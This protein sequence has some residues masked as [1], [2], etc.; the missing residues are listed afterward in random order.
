MEIKNINVKEWIGRYSQN[1][2][3]KKLL[4]VLSMD[5]LVRASGIILLPIYLRLMTQEEYGLYNYILSIIVT[6]S[7]I[8]NFGLYVSQTKFY[9]DNHLDEKRK[10]VLFNIAFL[11]SVAL[12]IVI[13]PVYVFRLDFDFVKILFKNDINYPRFRWAMLL[14]TIVSVYTV[15]LS[16]YF[17]TS[18]KIK[19]FRRYNLWRLIIVNVVALACLYYFRNDAIHIR[20]IC[21]YLSE[22]IVLAVFFSFYLR[23][24]FPRID[25]KII[26]NSLKLGLPIMF[27]AIWGL[28]SNYSDKFFLEKNGTA[29]DLSYYY[30]AFSIANVLYMICTAVQNSW[31]PSFLKEKDLK[32]NIRKTRKLISQLAIVLF[33]LSVMLLVGLYVAIKIKI[34]SDKYIP[35]MHVLPFLLVAQIINGIVLIYSN[36]M[37]YFERTHW[38]LFIGI[39]TSVIGLAG[40]YFLVPIWGVFGAVTSYLIVQVT[41]FY[42]Y[43]LVIRYKIRKME[44]V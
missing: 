21:T 39:F 41:Y 26:S 40:S 31:L 7:V 13:I 18:E 5:I 32:L 30:L 2:T 15:I 42:L 27:S 16:N 35:A 9:S 20:L 43:H 4:T 6:F 12:A 11:L 22:L 28:I 17:I 3:F 34:I 8:L 23:E 1:A 29:K 19:Y 38:S 37:I 44:V 33:V 25:F 36:Y 10:V 24:M 14:A